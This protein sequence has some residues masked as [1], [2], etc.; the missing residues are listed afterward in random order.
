MLPR[1]YIS[2]MKNWDRFDRYPPP[3]V[4]VLARKREAKRAFELSDQDIAVRAGMPVTRV[5]EIASTPTWDGISFGE[6]KSFCRGCNFDPLDSKDR[7]RAMAYTR[8]VSKGQLS[9]SYLKKDP[10]R[11]NSYYKPLI[12]LAL[13]AIK[14]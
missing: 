12:R 10:V 13:S 5:I 2:L 6:V 14:G 7:N 3:L 9:F 4:R 1:R 8:L 11:W